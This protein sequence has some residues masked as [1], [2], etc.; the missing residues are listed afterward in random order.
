[1]PPN[2]NV[3]P[4]EGYNPPVSDGTLSYQVVTQFEGGSLWLVGNDTRDSADETMVGEAIA[5]GPGPSTRFPGV[6]A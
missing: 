5:G 4:A 3:L 6:A 2:R 1:M